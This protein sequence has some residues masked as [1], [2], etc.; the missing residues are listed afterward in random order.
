MNANKDDM[1]GCFWADI[2][3]T[4]ISLFAKVMRHRSYTDSKTPRSTHTFTCKRVIIHTHL[5]TNAYFAVRQRCFLCDHGIE[6]DAVTH[7]GLIRT[8]RALERYKCAECNG[9]ERKLGLH[10]WSRT[11]ARQREGGI[12]TEK[13]RRER[14][15][16]KA[17]RYSFLFSVQH[18][19]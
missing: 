2:W 5:Q 18:F 15:K 14:G 9:T 7:S 4:K 16:Y 3:M 19:F 13:T 11:T 17:F 8:S 1:S 10:W 12:R 6:P